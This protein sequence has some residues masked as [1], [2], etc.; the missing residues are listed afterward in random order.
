ML[1]MSRI[2][3]VLALTVATAVA[4]YPAAA[5]TNGAPDGDTHPYV[6][7]VLTR[8]ANG[9]SRC[10]GTL[11]SS[12]LLVTAGHCTDG[13]TEPVQV[14]FEPGPI[15]PDPAYMNDGKCAGVHGYPCEGDAS[16]S[17]HTY[18]GYDPANPVTADVG[19]VVLDTPVGEG[20]YA[21]LP[22]Q[23]QL[24]AL[25]KGQEFTAVGYGQQRSSNNG[26]Q[27]VA[28]RQRMVS[29]PKL[30]KIDEKPVGDYGFL[31]TQNAS[32][33]GVCLGDSGGPMFLGAT[34][35]LAGVVSYVTNDTCTGS[36]GSFRLDRAGPLTW[37]EQQLAATT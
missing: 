12:T 16:G 37:L 9:F 32:T 22:E 25:V 20:P 34:T 36:A 29:H 7:L 24:D 13:I 14:W 3:A 4:A 30:A 10:T 6:G 35:V 17:A 28:I 11:V 18:P 23:D 21:Q 8:D 27:D 2:V 31:T 5:I 15:E 19:V 33:G 1:S 26:K